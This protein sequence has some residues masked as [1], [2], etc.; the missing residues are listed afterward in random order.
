LIASEY[1]WTTAQID[2]LPIDKEAELFHAILYR[3][4][5]KTYRRQLQ[6]ED[7]KPIEFASHEIDTNA[8]TEG[9]SW[10]SP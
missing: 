3:K 5:A 9:I 7:H 2:S 1:G 10:H 4:G 8:L 6:V